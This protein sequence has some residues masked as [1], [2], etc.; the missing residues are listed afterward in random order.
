MIKYIKA[1]EVHKNKQHPKSIEP[2]C[3]KFPVEEEYM[4]KYTAIASTWVS[5]TYLFSKD[6]TFYIQVEIIKT[7]K[8]FTYIKAG[9]EGYNGNDETRRVPHAI[10]VDTL[11]EGCESYKALQD[12]QISFLE[13]EFN[14]E[15]ANFRQ[16]I[17][18]K[19][20]LS[21]KYLAEACAYSEAIGIPFTSNVSQLAQQYTPRSLGEK[22]KSLTEEQRHLLGE[23]AGCYVGSDERDGWQHSQVC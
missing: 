20:E 21:E 1:K 12:A 9:F 18:E 7:D 16:K 11:P 8:D 5:P 15:I 14:A 22:A 4:S 13:K 23:L 3:L 19:L 6:D 10:V 2:R 17:K